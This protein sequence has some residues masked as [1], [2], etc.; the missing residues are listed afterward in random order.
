MHSR[1]R[2]SRS[3][4]GSITGR[5]YFVGHVTPIAHLTK[6]PTEPRLRGEV[7]ALKYNETRERG[8]PGFLQAGGAGARRVAARAF[9]TSRQRGDRGGRLARLPYTAGSRGGGRETLRAL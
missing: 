8:D 9:E 6:K 7:S 1:I 4:A 5:L 3:K 2:I